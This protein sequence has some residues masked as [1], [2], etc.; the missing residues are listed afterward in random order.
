M[1]VEILSTTDGEPLRYRLTG[2]GSVEPNTDTVTH[3]DD[4]TFTIENETSGAHEFE[5]DGTLADFEQI[6]SKSDWVLSVDG[7]PVAFGGPESGV[8]VGFAYATKQ[9]IQAFVACSIEAAIEDVAD[10]DVI[11]QLR[12]RIDALESGAS[13]TASLVESVQSRV[14]KLSERLDTYPTEPEI[15][16]LVQ[17][18]VDRRVSEVEEQVDSIER[19]AVTAEEVRSLFRDEL[20]HASIS[21]EDDVGHGGWSPIDDDVW[22]DRSRTEAPEGTGG[23][24]VWST[25]NGTLR[26][27]VEGVGRAGFYDEPDDDRLAGAPSNDTIENHDDDDTFTIEGKTGNSYGDAFCIDGYVTEFEVTEA[28]TPWELEVAGDTNPLRHYDG[29]TEG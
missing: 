2:S 29:E 10:A 28:G 3:H 21:F 5:I 9:Q 17:A 11:Q 8:D 20:A 1:N 13:E 22:N 4:G 23:L 7:E 19:E 14:D 16:E 6:D 24:A 18:R 27:R 15:E 26:Y 25:G 12:D